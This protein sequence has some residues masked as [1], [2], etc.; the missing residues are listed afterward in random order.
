[1]HGRFSTP[2]DANVSGAELLGCVAADNE[3]ASEVFTVSRTKPKRRWCGG[4]SGTLFVRGIMFK[5]LT[6]VLAFALLTLVTSSAPAETAGTDVSDGHAIEDRPRSATMVGVTAQIG[7]YQSNGLGLRLGPEAF[8]I[9]LS[10]GYR[11]LVL[12]I[13]THGDEVMK[14]DLVHSAQGE[15]EMIVRLM[16]MGRTGHLALKAGYRYNSVYQHGFGV[17]G[18]A[19][20]RL[21]QHSALRALYGFSIFPRAEHELRERNHLA[22]EE[23][24]LLP[25]G[26]ELSLSAGVVLYP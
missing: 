4:H 12:M 26:M 25:Y 5:S 1:M 8:A 19:E 9:E 2:D 13:P 16:R 21:T 22:P 3:R 11:P 17:G 23:E 10:G 24:L 20:R 14:W 15:A 7:Y 18:Y 6:E